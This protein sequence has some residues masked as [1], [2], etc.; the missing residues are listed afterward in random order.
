[1]E[2][3]LLSVNEYMF[4]LN[5]TLQDGLEAVR[6]LLL[7]GINKSATFVNSAKKIEQIGWG[8]AD[9]KHPFGKYKQTGRG[10]KD[11]YRLT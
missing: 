2:V 6:I 5:L 10:C 11:I 7:E 9:F 1:M 4:Q 3:W 8:I